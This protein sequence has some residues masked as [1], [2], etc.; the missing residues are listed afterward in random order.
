MKFMD[1]MKHRRLQE[2]D[3][4]DFEIVDGEPDIRG[5]DVRDR[6]GKKLGEVEDLIIDAQKKKAR[7]IV[8]DMDD[9]DFDLDDRKVLIPIGMA[10]LHE[11]DDDVIIPV[12]V[13]QL[14]TLPDYDSDRLDDTIERQIC[15]VFANGNQNLGRDKYTESNSD[16]TIGDEFYSHDYF[17]DDNLYKNRLHEARP[18]NT[19]KASD[20]ERGLRLWERRSEGG[21]LSGDTSGNNENYSSREN[22]KGDTWGGEMKEEERLEM[23]RNRRNNYE[24]RRHRDDSRNSYQDNVRDYREDNSIKRRTRDEGLRDG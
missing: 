20:Y 3:R 16:T 24:E 9:N 12:A 10:E 13:Q 18:A 4:S 22:R 7:Y 11:K 5:W 23:V 6:T 14:Q 1:N 17:N 15:S 19:N 21:I 8:L 2:M